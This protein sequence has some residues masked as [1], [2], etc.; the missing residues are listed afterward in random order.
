MV[1]PKRERGGVHRAPIVNARLSAVVELRAYRA[2]TRLRDAIWRAIL[3]T[4]ETAPPQPVEQGQAGIGEDVAIAGEAQGFDDMAI[5]AA[6]M[7]DHAALRQHMEHMLLRFRNIH[8]IIRDFQATKARRPIGR[9]A[10]HIPITP[11]C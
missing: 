2:E 11:G 4:D 10:A 8:G 3:R 1:A 9:R 5:F 6:P 7:A